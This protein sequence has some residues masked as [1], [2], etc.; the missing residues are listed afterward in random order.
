MTVRLYW[1]TAVM[2]YVVQT[3]FLSHVQSLNTNKNN[4]NSTSDSITVYLTFIYFAS[5]LLIFPLSKLLKDNSTSSLPISNQIENRINSENLNLNHK[6]LFSYSYFKYFVKI[7]TLAILAL[8][9]VLSYHTALAITP[10]FD[11]ALIQNTSKF[12]IT[13]LLFGICGIA[14]RK[15]IFRNYVI[16][17][18]GLLGVLL[19][20][21]TKATCDFLSGKLTINQETGEL[22][23]PF[24]F[25]RLKG[26]LICGLGA[27]TTGPFAV[28]YNR[29]F[30]TEKD[31]FVKQGNHLLLI[32]IINMI[33]LSPFF[34]TVSSS[35]VSLLYSG[36][37]FWLP[38][39][40]SIALGTLPHLLS[41]LYLNRNAIPEYL[42]TTNLGI[43][44]TMGLAEWI[45][46]P[47]QTFIVR[48]EVIGYL[49][50]SVACVILSISFYDTRHFH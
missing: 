16:I 21:Y 10:A 43:I 19:I 14:K 27:L 20:A 41:L 34:P 9:T 44:I 1:F 36:K 31:S 18:F 49:L 8:V 47:T 48:W 4:D 39:L 40:S 26:A 7:F 33:L 3:K 35:S 11:V 32:G 12:E 30:N 42:T 45:C 50:L 46:E 37:E 38:V 13:I 5:W 24:L 28:L 6:Q 23:D 29:W 15:N 25:D 2:G 17:M 22:N